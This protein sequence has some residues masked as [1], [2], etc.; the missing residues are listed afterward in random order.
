M[1]DRFDNE[2]PGEGGAGSLML[3][4]GLLLALMA[5]IATAAYYL[6]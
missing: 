4:G 6:I 1:I 3:I 2:E 5:T